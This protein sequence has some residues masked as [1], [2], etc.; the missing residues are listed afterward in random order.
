MENKKEVISKK[1]LKQLISM[2]EDEDL[3]KYRTSFKVG[4]PFKF[5]RH[6][7]KD[8]EEKENAR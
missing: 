1:L 6:S 7:L 5:E 3:L 4:K 2:S 8:L